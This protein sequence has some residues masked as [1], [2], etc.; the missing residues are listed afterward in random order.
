[1]DWIGLILQILTILLSD[2]TDAVALI[3]LIGQSG[4]KRGRFWQIDPANTAI[5]H[6]ASLQIEN[7]PAGPE[8]VTT[9]ELKL[10]DQW[11]TNF[12]SLNRALGSPV[13]ELPSLPARVMPGGRSPRP[14]IFAWDVERD[15][16]RGV[17]MMTA[18]NAN[19]DSDEISV[20][21]ILV[22]RYYN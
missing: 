10:V 6:Q 13:R 17:V 22:R 16:R 5:I 3:G 11:K 19:G 21:E 20:T 8:T 14:K 12:T 9:V 2:K 7:L 1:M 15:G 18:L 4:E